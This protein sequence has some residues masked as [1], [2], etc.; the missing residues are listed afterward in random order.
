MGQG[1]DG[2]VRLVLDPNVLISAVLSKNGAP[3]RLVREWLRGSFELVVSE[4]LLDELRRA[5]AYPELRE[6]IRPGEAARLLDALRAGATMAPDP[7]EPHDVRS[8]DPNDD[9]LIALAAAQ[10]AMLVTGDSDLLD[11]RQRAP[12]RSPREALE[13][14]A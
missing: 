2:V 13:L 11:L 7:V 9:Y 5:L 6:L 12:I 4:A 10:S 3:A 14:L 1:I 8:R